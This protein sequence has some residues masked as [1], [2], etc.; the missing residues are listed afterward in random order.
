MAAGT[1]A[2]SAR[3]WRAFG[4]G[5]EELGAVCCGLLDQWERAEADNGGGATEV[6]D[7]T[8]SRPLAVSDAAS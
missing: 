6:V 7:S 8:D 4:V 2:G 1:A 3:W 5:T